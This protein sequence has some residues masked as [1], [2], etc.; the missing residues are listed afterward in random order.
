ME[1]AYSLRLLH[2]S[3]AEAFEKNK[4]CKDFELQIATI[5]GTPAG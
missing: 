1:Y 4:Y 2:A 5:W 3:N